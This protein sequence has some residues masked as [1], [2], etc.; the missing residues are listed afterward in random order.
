MIWGGCIDV[1]RGA[2]FAVCYKR[3]HKAEEVIMQRIVVDEKQAEIIRTARQ[4][5]EIR[6]DT[7]RLIDYITPLPSEEDLAR[8]R[9]RMEE[10]RCRKSH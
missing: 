2:G 10:R 1:G 7:G 4:K 5:V 8:A 6:D 3:D 9:R